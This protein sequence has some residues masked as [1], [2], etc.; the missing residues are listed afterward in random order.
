MDRKDVEA[1]IN[2]LRR[3]TKV[4][5]TVEDVNALPEGS[6]EYFTGSGIPNDSARKLLF[7]Q[8]SI[9]GHYK[10]QTVQER[11]LPFTLWQS[12]DLLDRTAA[13]LES[14]LELTTLPGSS[15]L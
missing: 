7:D 9:G 6:T 11:W 5:R 13:A 12:G 2:E 10:S 8:W 4:L 1:L 15:K 3:G 14:L